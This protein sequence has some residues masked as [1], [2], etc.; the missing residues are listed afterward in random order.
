[1]ATRVVPREVFEQWFDILRP[2]AQR[3]DLNEDRIQEVVQ[4]AS[5]IAAFHSLDQLCGCGS[6]ETHV[7]GSTGVHADRFHFASDEK[8]HQAVLKADAQRL[9]VLEKHRSAIRARQ[10]AAHNTAFSKYPP[11]EMVRLRL[12]VIASDGDERTMAADTMPMNEPANAPFA[13]AVF[14]CEHHACPDMRSEFGL[15]A[16]FSSSSARTDQGSRNFC[17]CMF[18]AKHGA[19]VNSNGLATPAGCRSIEIFKKIDDAWRVCD[20]PAS[21]ER[22]KA[23]TCPTPRVA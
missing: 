19:R 5:K 3:R 1:M 15:L 18:L 21:A 11:F 2:L 4:V 8:F 12:R 10:G 17:G 7:S 6:E 13:D 9:D 23:D 14:A 16:Q 22:Q 20:G